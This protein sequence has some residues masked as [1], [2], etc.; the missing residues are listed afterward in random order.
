M[1]PAA[2]TGGNVS[3]AAV[4][5]GNVSSAAV[6]GGNVS[7]AA[8][9]GGNVSSAAVTGGNVSRAAVTGGNVSSAAVT[10]GNVSKAAV[11]GG[12]VSSAAVTGGNV[13]RAAVTG[14]NV[15][16][17]A[18]TGGNVSRAAV[19]GGNVSS[20][21]VTGGNVSRAA[22]T[23]GNVSSA[24]VT[25]G[26]VSRAAVTGGNGSSAAVT[27]GNVSR[28]IAGHFIDESQVEVRIG[29][30][31]IQLH[32]LF[33]IAARGRRVPPLDRNHT[34]AVI[35]RAV[36]RVDRERPFV[37]ALGIPEKAFLQIRGGKVGLALQVG[38]VE[39]R[40]LLILGNGFVLLAGAHEQV[41]EPGVQPPALNPAGDRAAIQLHGIRRPPGP[42]VC[43][44]EFIV[45][46]GIGG[47]FGERLPQQ[48]DTS[49]HGKGAAFH[50]FEQFQD[51]SAVF[52]I[53]PL[54]VQVVRAR[55]KSG[56]VTERLQLA[57]S[58]LVHHAGPDLLDAVA[59][60]HRV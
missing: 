56:N 46:V 32:R 20:A 38:G 3:K 31:R 44:A 23:G 30:F 15:S 11:T 36:P 43:G 10:G 57:Q 40:C 60:D 12:N 53:D 4:T 17:A 55:H 26:N 45:D 5:G 34:Q 58:A 47:I 22:V 9:T 16:S 6:T 24:A 21:A 52:G 51:A 29:Q 18:V 8:V 13:S 7:R 41:G 1:S 33:E 2:V 54:P 39:L 27:G 19:T 48:L 49:R 14:G 59:P 25:G 28:A 37:D 35:G 50:R 42:L